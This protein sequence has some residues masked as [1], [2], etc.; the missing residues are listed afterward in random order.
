MLSFEPYLSN[1]ISTINFH[2][3]LK[4][5]MQHVWILTDPKPRHVNSKTILGQSF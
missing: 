3:L 1:N 5:Q 4:I 2:N